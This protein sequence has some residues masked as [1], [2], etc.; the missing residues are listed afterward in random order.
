MAL[1]LWHSWTCP[2]GMSVRVALTEKGV[3]YSEHEL[4]PGAKPAELLALNPKGTVPVLVVDGEVLT[5]SNAILARLEER[6]PS[7]PLLPRGD[8]RSAALEFCA[9]A[10]REVGRR[11]PKVRRGTPDEKALAETELR[12]VFDALELEAPERGFWFGDFS[13]A[14]VTLV[15]FL[16]RLPDPLRPRALGFSKLANWERT[17]LSRRSVAAHTA[18]RRPVPP[19]REARA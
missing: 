18:P 8:R 17:V 2:Y 4:E 12:S 16:A 11:L 13:L 14:D 5:D 19:E 7:P 6:Y 10:T 3:A 1:E 15:C 9:R